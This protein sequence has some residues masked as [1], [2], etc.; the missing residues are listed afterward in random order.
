MI[1]NYNK[2]S[3]ESL[4]LRMYDQR[5]KSSSGQAFRPAVK[6]VLSTLYSLLLI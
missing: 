3:F 4:S 1:F 6:E 5:V 2:V